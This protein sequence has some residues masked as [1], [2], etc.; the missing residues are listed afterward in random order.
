MKNTAYKM[1]L[2]LVLCGCSAAGGGKL[3][4]FGK[5]HSGSERFQG[6]A[7]VFANGSTNVRMTSPA[8]VECIG[9]FPYAGNNK[10]KA[11]LICTDGR[12]A[13]MTFVALSGTSGYGYGAVGDGTAIEFFFGLPKA[14]AD[15]YLGLATPPQ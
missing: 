9:Y 6:V 2:T 5:S 14:E 11:D 8:G 15:V 12:V 3:D 1:L 13:R 4:V 10:R 7:T